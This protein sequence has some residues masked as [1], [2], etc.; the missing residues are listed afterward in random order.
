LQPNLHGLKP[1]LRQLNPKASELSREF[2]D[3]AWDRAVEKR[4]LED[5]T[6]Q[7]VSSVAASLPGLRTQ[8]SA[9]YSAAQRLRRSQCNGDN[10][11]ATAWAARM[12]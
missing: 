8:R 1:A 5:K 12:L 6:N 7:I 4:L 3:K 2:M 10:T 9:R 11:T